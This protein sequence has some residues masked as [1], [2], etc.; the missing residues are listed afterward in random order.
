MFKRHSASKPKP[1]P[2]R[3]SAPKPPSHTEAHFAKH[4]DDSSDEEETPRRIKSYLIEQH[5]EKFFSGSR[6]N[7]KAALSNDELLSFIAHAV[8]IKLLY[9]DNINVRYYALKEKLLTPSPTSP[10]GTQQLETLIEAAVLRAIKQVKAPLANFLMVH[11]SRH[12]T[13]SIVD[14]MET[15]SRE[16]LTKKFNELFQLHQDSFIALVNEPQTTLTQQPMGNEFIAT[17]STLIA[18][19]LLRH[20]TPA[21]TPPDLSA[22]T[23]TLAQLAVEKMWSLL[24]QLALRKLIN[25]D[26]RQQAIDI[27]AAAKDPYQQLRTLMIEILNHQPA[28][29]YIETTFQ[30]I[31][32]RDIYQQRLRQAYLNDLIHIDSLKETRRY[33]SH[34]DLKFFS[35]YT[36]QH[37]EN[38]RAE[39]QR[40]LTDALE[41]EISAAVRTLHRPTL[42][43][44]HIFTSQDA[45]HFYANLRLANRSQK[46][47][48]RNL[49]SAMQQQDTVARLWQFGISDIGECA[50]V[51]TQHIT[52]THL[53]RKDLVEG[54]GS[55]DKVYELIKQIKSHCSKEGAAITDE[56]IAQWLRNIFQGT[57]PTFNSSKIDT[58]LLQHKLQSITYLLF[59]CEVTRNPAMGVINQMLLDLILAKQMTFA[60]AFVGSD[61]ADNHLKQPKLMP[62]SPKGAVAV[63]RTLHAAYKEAMPH[64]YQYPGITDSDQRSSTFNH[65]DMIKYEAQIVRSW[66]MHTATIPK[67]LPLAGMAT[68]CFNLIETQFERWF[69]PSETLTSTKS[70]TTSMQRFSL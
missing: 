9:H 12:K 2:E 59:G 67:R 37:R 8:G 40:H 31:L 34:A 41:K 69:K 10:T 53:G 36:A 68:W 4:Y 17:I 29:C 23:A 51:E 38:V 63:A 3:E 20:Y 49:Q 5:C 48:I 50:V 62:M 55:Y 64:P 70:L 26:G 46:R 54:L 13:E 65:E 66:L 16:Q 15:V 47:Q 56:T 14:E 33:F 18:T 35:L 19:P 7:T 24:E 44:H 58:L 39:L 43:K 21:K 52:G 28:N 45:Y 11:S 6:S 1:T 32:Q 60:E 27:L 22:M 57:V 42:G 25:A 61:A 30:K